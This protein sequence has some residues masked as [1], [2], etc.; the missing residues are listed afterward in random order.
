MKP[1]TIF[2]W[3]LILTLAAP[4]SASGQDLPPGF[5]NW[6]TGTF[7]LRISKKN[8]IRFSQLYA[9]NTKPSGLQF[10]Q[11]NVSF[12]RRLN[13]PW[14]AG[15][16]YAHS[17]F[18]SSSGSFNQYH[19][20]FVSATHRQYW[21]NFRGK[22]GGKAEFHFPQLRKWQYRFIVSHKLSWRNKFFPFKGTPYIKNQLYY[23]A[24]G[25]EVKYWELDES[26]EGSEEYVLGAERAPNGWHR[27]RFT[28]GMRFRFTKSFAGSFYYTIQREF[29]TPWN[30]YGLN[31]YNKS[32]TRI[33]VPFNNFS[34]VGVSL[35]YTLKTYKKKRRPSKK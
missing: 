18:K 34:L 2:K 12:D 27:Y 16:G 8:T 4:L 1:L 17:A 14:S 33:K 24:G 28:A 35:S 5:K 22:L 21:G 20:V 31:V 3:A 13:K 10:I 30:P 19:R 29:N 7:N 9:F 11:S 25:R 32:Q 6:A 23:Y 15:F 26:E